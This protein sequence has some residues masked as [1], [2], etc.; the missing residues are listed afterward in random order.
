MNITIET[1]KSTA[2]TKVAWT[3]CTEC[4]G[5]LQVTYRSGGTYTF[6]GVLLQDVVAIAAAADTGGSMGSMLHAAVGH[7]KGALVPA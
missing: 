5:T 2:F 4:G 3:G 7:R 6:H 1:T